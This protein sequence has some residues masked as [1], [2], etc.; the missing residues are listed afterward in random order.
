MEIEKLQTYQQVIDSLH[1]KGRKKHLLFGTG[2]SMAYDRNIFSYNALSNFIETT[3]DPLIK[4]LFKK[5]NTKNF[6][7]I[8]VVICFQIVS[9]TF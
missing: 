6:E 7:L 4:S 1:K 5:L 3:G 8:K 9:L 2:F